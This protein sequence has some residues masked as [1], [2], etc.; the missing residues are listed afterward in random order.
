MNTYHWLHF[1]GAHRW[2]TKGGKWD[3]A[4]ANPESEMSSRS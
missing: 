3:V 1:E 4:M 2:E